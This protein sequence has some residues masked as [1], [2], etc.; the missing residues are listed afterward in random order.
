MP[1]SFNIRTEVVRWGTAIS[2]YQRSVYHTAQE[3]NKDHTRVTVAE[4]RLL[5]A[6]EGPPA[7]KKK[8][9]HDIHLH[10]NKHKSRKTI[11]HSKSTI[12]MLFHPGIGYREQV[13]QQPSYRCLLPRVI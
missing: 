5:P 4:S 1:P 11:K 7:K 6:S 13:Y 9:T 12:N 8:Q 2:P 10:H 3:G